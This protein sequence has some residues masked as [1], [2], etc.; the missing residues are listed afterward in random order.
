MRLTRG[1][2]IALAVATVWPPLYMLLFLGVFVVAFASLSTASQAGAPPQGM[3]TLFLVILPL[4]IL[5]MIEG[6]GL[7]V[8]YVLHALNNEKLDQNTR[9]LWAILLFVGQFI[10][11]LIYFY[12]YVLPL[13]DDGLAAAE[14]D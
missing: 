5:T 4:H 14:E 9:L 8:V 1:K 2:K 12:Q 6:L 3:P 13:S 11:M 7:L 10:A